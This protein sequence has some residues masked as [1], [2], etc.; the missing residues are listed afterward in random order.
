MTGKEPW[1][2]NME[3][4]CNNYSCGYRTDTKS[5]HSFDK[6]GQRLNEVGNLIYEFGCTQASLGPLRTVTLTKRIVYEYKVY[7]R[8]E[9]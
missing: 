7:R 5:T 4:T 9:V 6:L 1:L 2:C 3:S 8:K